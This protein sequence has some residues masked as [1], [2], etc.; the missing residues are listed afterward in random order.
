[1]PRRGEFAEAHL[2]LAIA[3]QSL[4]NEAEAS[5]NFEKAI[6][7]KPELADAGSQTVQ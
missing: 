4:G 6:K 2:N 5:K 3:H 1:M 7:L